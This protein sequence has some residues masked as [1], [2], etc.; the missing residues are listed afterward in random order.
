MT[1]TLA[2]NKANRIPMQL[3]GPCPKAWKAYLKQKKERIADDYQ[4]RKCLQLTDFAQLFLLLKSV[5]DK[6]RQGMSSVLDLGEERQLAKT[7]C[8]PS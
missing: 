3:R 5:Q 7:P 4:V 6:T 1:A 2:S 8:H